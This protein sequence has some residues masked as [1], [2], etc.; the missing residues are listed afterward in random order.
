MGQNVLLQMN[1]RHSYQMFF[2]FLIKKLFLD[3]K[4][5]QNLFLNKNNNQPFDFQIEVCLKNKN[6]SQTQFFLVN[7]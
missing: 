2:F 6:S 1:E 7:H 3:C 5:M 4:I